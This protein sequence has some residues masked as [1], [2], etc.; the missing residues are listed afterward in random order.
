MDLEPIG[1]WS[2]IVG[3]VIVLL[4]GV[5]AIPMA[6][7]VLFVLGLIVGFLNIKSKETE[8]FLIATIA[9]I[10]LGIASIQTLT[11]LGTTVG[12]ALN[13][14]L[15]SLIAFAG[16]SALIVAVKAVLEIGKA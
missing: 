16:A 1:K 14:I 11:I 4:T 5:I 13:T 6:A 7:L 9:L 8:K 10:L 2:F 12:T 3:L 15:A